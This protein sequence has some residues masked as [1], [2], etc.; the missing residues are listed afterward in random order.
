MNPI[1]PFWCWLQKF[2]LRIGSYN[3]LGISGSWRI[4]I[5]VGCLLSLMIRGRLITISGIFLS[6]W[7]SLKGCQ[8]NVGLL[9]LVL[10]V[11]H[12]CSVIV[13]SYL[14]FIVHVQLAIWAISPMTSRWWLRSI[15]SELIFHTM[16][17]VFGRYSLLLR[18]RVSI[19]LGHP[20]R[21]SLWHLIWQLLRF[22]V[23][24]LLGFC[25]KFPCGSRGLLLLFI[26]LLAFLREV[27]VDLLGRW[28]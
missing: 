7:P 26:K 6:I 22:G 21:N 23:R 25:A 12:D 15:P 3:G 9:L 4:E 27:G 20:Q 18:C 19:V 17:G 5:S 28:I 13:R 10:I 24:W 14:T 1:V 11:A 2:D 8:T 16:I